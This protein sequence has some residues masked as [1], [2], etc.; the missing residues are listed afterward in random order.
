M[1]HKSGSSPRQREDTAR[2]IAA[3]LA[4]L[5]HEARA[6]GFADTVSALE[7]VENTVLREGQPGVPRQTQV[8]RLRS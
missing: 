6:A 7:A 5:R 1:R 8:K 3:A 2:Q 4:Y